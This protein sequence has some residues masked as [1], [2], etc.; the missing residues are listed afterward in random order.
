MKTTVSVEKGLVETLMKETGARNKSEA[1]RIAARGEIRR[2]KKQRLLRL[3]G[4]I[5]FDLEAEELRHR[6]SRLGR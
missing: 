5:D 2:R 1:V 4:R 6:N 3:P